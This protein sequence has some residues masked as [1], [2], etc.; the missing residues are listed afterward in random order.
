MLTIRDLA[1]NIQLEGRVEVRKVREDDA[2]T[3]WRDNEFTGITAE[4]EPYA[5][6][7]ITYMFP[8][9]WTNNTGCIVIEIK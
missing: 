2:I 1:N 6:S 7:E 4:L 9:G 3:V 8:I 5:D